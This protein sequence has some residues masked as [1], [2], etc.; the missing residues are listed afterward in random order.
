MKDSDFVWILTDQ[1]DGGYDIY[2]SKDSAMYAALNA[3][4]ASYGGTIP[5]DVLEDYCGSSH[6][7]DFFIYLCEHQH[8][9][10]CFNLEVTVRVVRD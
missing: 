7:D 3:I 9:L 5:T 4:R 8:R 2:K 6:E 1:E 10:H